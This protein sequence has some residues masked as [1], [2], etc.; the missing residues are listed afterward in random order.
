MIQSG[1]KVAELIEDAF[2]QAQSK[3]IAGDIDQVLHKNRS[4]EF[5]N[6]IH[7]NLQDHF[8]KSSYNIVV[9]SGHIKNTNF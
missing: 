8:N 5:I 3:E 1:L 4:T 7:A 6:H 9:F 2:Q